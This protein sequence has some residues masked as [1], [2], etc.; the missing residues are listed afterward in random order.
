MADAVQFGSEPK[1][2]DTSEHDAKMVEKFEAASATPEPEV[3]PGSAEKSERPSWLPD[4]FDTPEAFAEAYKALTDGK[5]DGEEPTKAPEDEASGEGEEGPP[6]TEDKTEE[7][8]EEDLAKKGLDFSK[9]REKVD[10]SGA[11]E[12]ADYAELDKAGYP[13]DLVDEFIEG[14]KA[15]A[16]VIRERVL[17]TVGGEEEFARTI[18]WAKTG[19]SAEEIEA[20]NESVDGKKTE[21]QLKVAVQGLYARYQAAN[22]RD[23]RLLRGTTTGPA[24]DVFESSA[25]LTAAMRDPRYAKDPAYRSQVQ[26]KLARSNIL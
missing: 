21:A 3:L 20:F 1:T 23:P 19:L 22:G 14:Q 6:E 12:E 11:L 9:Y 7:K 4:E 25:Q 15:I 26:A 18:E 16:S 13:K 17:K 10:T 24:T 2:V 8:V 5:K